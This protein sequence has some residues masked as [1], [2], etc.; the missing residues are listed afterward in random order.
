VI[1]ALTCKTCN[2]NYIGQTSHGLNKRFQ[3]HVRYVKDNNPQ[4]DFTK[5]ILHSRHE[6]GKIDDKMKVVKP[7]KV[8]RLLIPHELLF[9]QTFYQENTLIN[10][11]NPGEHNPLI[12]LAIDTTDAPL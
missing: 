12:Q 1:Y 4:S 7:V 6:Y 10:E 9:I 11:Q 2:H 3:E 8:T 5:H